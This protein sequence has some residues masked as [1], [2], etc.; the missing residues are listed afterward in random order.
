[1]TD[2]ERVAVLEE[3]LRDAQYAMEAAYAEAT[4]QDAVSKRYYGE[5]VLE[6]EERVKSAVPGVW[7]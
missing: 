1:M 4:S 3:L 7:E 5:R 6:W 2:K